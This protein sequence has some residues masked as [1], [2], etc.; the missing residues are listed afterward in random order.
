LL[1]CCLLEIGEE[2]LLQ[3][4]NAVGR[5]LGHARAEVDVSW[6]VLQNCLK[7]LEMSLEELQQQATNMHCFYSSTTVEEKLK[8]VYY[9]SEICEVLLCIDVLDIHLQELFGRDGVPGPLP[10][11]NFWKELQEYLAR[12]INGRIPPDEMPLPRLHE[13]LTDLFDHANSCMGDWFNADSSKTARY[14]TALDKYYFRKLDVIK[15][16]IFIL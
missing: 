14:Q 1:T 2:E 4:A 15:S 16:D 3:F 12:K 6:E 9:D 8:T 11:P 7:E 5:L 10:R 13:K